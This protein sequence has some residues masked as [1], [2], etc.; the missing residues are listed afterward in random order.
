MNATRSQATSQ[1]TSSSKD[2]Y[3]N[4]KGSSCKKPSKDS[5]EKTSMEMSIPILDIGKS[6]RVI[7]CRRRIAFALKTGS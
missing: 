7:W 5:I 1:G 6:Q 2:S 3:K 4:S